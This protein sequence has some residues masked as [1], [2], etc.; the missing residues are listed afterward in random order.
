MCREAGGSA[1]DA[2]WQATATTTRERVVKEEAEVE[3]ARPAGQ[4]AKA[5]AVGVAGERAESRAGR[6]EHVGARGLVAGAPSHT[7]CH[8]AR[9][10]PKL[11]FRVSHASSSQPPVVCVS[12]S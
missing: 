10:K 9:A 8:I 5:E 2:K 7:L 1:K 12:H 4:Q 3:G 11:L 6:R